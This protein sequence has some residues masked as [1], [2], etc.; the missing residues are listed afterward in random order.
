MDFLSDI[1]PLILLLICL[2]GVAGFLAGLLGVGGGIVLVP[3]LFYL[4]ESMQSDFGFDSSYLMHLSVATSLAIIVPTGF[5]SARSHFKRESVDFALVRGIGLGIVVGVVLAS[6]IASGLDAQSM[7]IIFATAIMI[8]AVVMIVGRSRFA[9]EEQV[10]FTFWE[11][12]F[13]GIVI[14]CISALIGIGGAT[15]SVPY[16]SMKGVKMHRA[17]GTASALGLVIAVPATISYMVIGWHIENLPPYS[18]GYVNILAWACIIP[19]S[20]AVAPLG[21]KAA[22]MVSV[23]KLK[24][25]F[26]IFM[27]LVALN[28]WRKVLMGA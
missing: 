13:S 1:L 16:M 9:R 15:L 6:W 11:S 25:T 14:G 8:L 4:F 10:P 20:V 2:G 28:M 18:I 23:K 5:S 3:G 26:A 27:V 12:S 7:K 22:H 21:A 24:I 17:V 19:V